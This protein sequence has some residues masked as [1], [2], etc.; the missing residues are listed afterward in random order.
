MQILLLGAYRLARALALSSSTGFFILVS[1]RVVAKLS[2]VIETF[3]GGLKFKYIDALLSQDT[4]FK[5]LLVNNRAS[6]DGG[7]GSH[8]GLAQTR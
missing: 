5:T 1:V 8:S 2:L 3:P 4:L 6:P 7:L